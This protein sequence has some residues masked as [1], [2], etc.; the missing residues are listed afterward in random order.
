MK[1]ICL[2][3]ASGSIGKSTCDILKKF[4]NSFELV[5]VSINKSVDILESIILQFPS[6]KSVCVCNAPIIELQKKYPRI[7]FFTKEDGLI[8]LIANSSC[9]MVVNALVGFVG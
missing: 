9:D 8:D 1:K 6:I 5:A 3:G 4:N 7:T 2:L